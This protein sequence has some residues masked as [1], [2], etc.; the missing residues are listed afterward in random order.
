LTVEIEPGVVVF[1]DAIASWLKLYEQKKH[2][3]KVIDDELLRIREVLE[4]AMG[5]ANVALHNGQE[6][7]RFT[8]VQAKR[9]DV[10]KAREVLPSEFIQL[11]ETT[12]TSKRFTL[13]GH[14]GSDE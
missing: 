11:L 10:K 2:E 1:D 13:V 9:F 4:A 3:R 12:I 7:A 8:T 5:D 6:V 14:E